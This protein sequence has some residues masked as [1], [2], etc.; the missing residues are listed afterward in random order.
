MKSNS[1]DPQYIKLIEWMAWRWYKSHPAYKEDIIQLA[2]ESF[3][4]ANEDWDKFDKA[5]RP[6]IDYGKFINV[7]TRSYLRQKVL[8]EINVVR[9]SSYERLNL[10][11]KPRGLHTYCSDD[12][13]LRTC[14]YYPNQ[15]NYC[16]RKTMRKNLN[17]FY[18]TLKPRR[19][20]WLKLWMDET[21]FTDIAAMYGV[22]K[23][24][25]EQAIKKDL[26]KFRKIY[27]GSK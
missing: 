7:H 16:D 3:L 24:C 26:K 11:D 27:Y 15:E 12:V 13:L 25:I 6:D 22:T 8:D 17:E 4:L 20:E 1:I 10:K 14:C 23:Q 19:K 9:L 2:Y 5:S 21:S 18:E